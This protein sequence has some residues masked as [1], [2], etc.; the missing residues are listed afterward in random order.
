MQVSNTFRAHVYVITISRY[1]SSFKFKRTKSERKSLRKRTSVFV[2]YNLLR[3][4]KAKLRLWM[5]FMQLLHTFL[6]LSPN[7]RLSLYLVYPFLKYHLHSKVKCMPIDHYEKMLIYYLLSN[8]HM[9]VCMQKVPQSKKF[10]SLAQNFT[11][12]H[13]D[14]PSVS[15]ILHNKDSFINLPT[16][17]LFFVSLLEIKLW[18]VK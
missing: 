12:W 10:S 18:S 7:I 1:F 2:E 15:Q 17:C 9:H 13:A 6:F 4:I 11:T 14:F 8:G 3:N 16:N 5:T